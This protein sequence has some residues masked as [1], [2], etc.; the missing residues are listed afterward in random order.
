MEKREQDK[1]FLKSVYKY[2]LKKYGKTSSGNAPKESRSKE[3]VDDVLDPNHD[4]EVHPDK[5]PVKKPGVLN[6]AKK[7]TP[8]PPKAKGKNEL[9][10]NKPKVKGVKRLKNYMRKGKD[11]DG[12]C[13][14][15]Y[16]PTPGKKPYSEGSCRK[17]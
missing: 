13:W 3:V 17:K 4:A 2:M 1:Q 15:G 7:E 6:K 16:E 5:V 12:R 8:K 10:P 11:E 9:P 14:D